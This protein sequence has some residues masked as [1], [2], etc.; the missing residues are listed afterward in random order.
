[1]FGYVTQGM[2]EV[3]DQIEAGDRIESAEVVE[4][5]EN[6]TIKTNSSQS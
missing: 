1:M 5:I 3:V 2:K 4:G 6:L